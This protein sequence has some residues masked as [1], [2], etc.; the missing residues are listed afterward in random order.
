MWQN[1]SLKISQN[2][3]KLIKKYIEISEYTN[4][5]LKYWLQVYEK[6]MSHM[7]S[8]YAHI[9]CWY[10]ILSKIFTQM[11][12][13]PKICEIWWKKLEVVIS[14]PNTDE[15]APGL[16][17]KCMKYMYHKK[18]Q[19]LEFDK[20]WNIIRWKFKTY[21]IKKVTTFCCAELCAEMYSNRT[22]WQY[23]RQLR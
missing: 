16:I 15:R 3:F 22:S 12:H 21:M 11:I 13:I 2:W 8:H 5:G 1:A 19:I 9:Q 18:I 6:Y 10:S 7:I 17:R 23:F 20:T 4:I 14:T